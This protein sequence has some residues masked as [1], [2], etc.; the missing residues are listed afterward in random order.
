MRG[1]ASHANSLHPRINRAPGY[2]EWIIARQARWPLYIP[3]ERSY[4]TGA[5]LPGT[6]A[7]AQLPDRL[8]AA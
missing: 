6:T 4:G 3:Y 8:V 2:N 5:P 7:R 1:L